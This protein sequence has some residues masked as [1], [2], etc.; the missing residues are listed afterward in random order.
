MHMDK[1]LKR[2]AHLEFIND[3]IATE[4]QQVDALLRSIGFSEGLKSVK[5][6][7]KEIYEQEHS[8]PVMK[9][10]KPKKG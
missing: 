10:R 1:L 9:K 2:L 4:L 5:G 3:Q 8:A 7:A 6:A